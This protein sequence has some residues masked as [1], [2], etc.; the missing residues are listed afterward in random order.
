MRKMIKHTIEILKEKVKGNLLEIRQNKDEIRRLQE[1][2]V[3][4]ESSAEL[5]IK[6]SISRRLLSENTDFI[7][8]QLTLANFVEKYHDSEIF[9]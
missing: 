2:P 6:Y 3:S 8:V 9:C 4:L 7:N 1:L 5:E